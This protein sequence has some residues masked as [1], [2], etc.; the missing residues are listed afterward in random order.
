MATLI[1]VFFLRGGGCDKQRSRVRRHILAN[2]LTRNRENRSSFDVHSLCRWRH[3]ERDFSRNTLVNHHCAAIIFNERVFMHSAHLYEVA[4]TRCVMKI[5]HAGGAT[6]YPQ[7]NSLVAASRYIACI[8]G[9][10]INLIR[11]S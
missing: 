2:V 1:N 3:R 4:M 6:R 10:R 8:I 5:R 9:A 11:F 7:V